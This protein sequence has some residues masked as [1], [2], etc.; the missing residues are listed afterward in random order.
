MNYQEELQAKLDAVR[1]HDNDTQ[2]EALDFDAQEKK[3]LDELALDLELSQYDLQESDVF[4]ALK[5]DEI[6]AGYGSAFSHKGALKLFYTLCRM[7][8]I[9]AKKLLT[10]S[11]L[12]LQTFKQIINGFAK[13]GLV[14]KNETSELELTMDGKSLASRIG[15]DIFI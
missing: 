7:D 12:D 1:A 10:F 5:I 2:R 6:L 14:F 3:L 9:T 8:V 4:R 13:E 11:L 15:V